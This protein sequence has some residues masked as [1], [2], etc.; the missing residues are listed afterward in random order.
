MIAVTNQGIKTPDSRIA[1]KSNRAPSLRHGLHSFSG[2]RPR[3]PSRL[4]ELK[5][6]D[7]YPVRIE[8]QLALDQE[9]QWL[10]ATGQIERIYRKYPCPNGKANAIHELIVDR[11]AARLERQEIELIVFPGQAAACFWLQANKV[12]GR[13]E[14]PAFAEIP[15]SARR[16]LE[17]VGAL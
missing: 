10:C 14:F 12:K 16:R 4:P 3:H 2:V 13:L 7:E 15:V 9:L 11:L 5:A 17:A 8:V 1:G 6:P